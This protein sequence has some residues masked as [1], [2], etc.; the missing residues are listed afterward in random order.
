MKST[1]GIIMKEQF[2]INPIGS[3][4]SIIKKEKTR[5]SKAWLVW[6]FAGTAITSL[7]MVILF[8]HTNVFRDAI[9]AGLEL[10]NGTQA[11]D[12][13]EKPP[14]NPVLRV[15]IFNYTNVEEYA[16]G[17]ASKLQVE[18]LGPYIYRETISRVNVR[19]NENG[20][21]SYQEK[22]THK[23]EG[24]RS[25]DEMIRVPNVPLI[26]AVKK[27]RE[28]SRLLHIPATFG[29]TMMGAKPFKELTVKEY[30]WGYNDN[31][32]DTAM[33]I[34]S[35]TETLPYDKFGML[36]ARSGLSKD[37]LTVHT[38]SGDINN[39]GLY[40]NMNGMETRNVWGDEECDRVRGT[41]GSIFPPNLVRDRNAT[42]EIYTKDMCRTF[43]LRYH[44]DG[45]VFDI[46]SLRYKPT[47][48]IFTASNTTNSCFCQ[49]TS[50]G[51]IKEIQTCPPAGVFNISACSYNL[52]LLISFPHFYGGEKSLLNHVEGMSPCQE[53]HETYADLHPRLGVL[54]GGW[55]RLQI[56]V[57]VSVL[58]TVDMLGPL[59]DGAILPLVW[60]E[61]GVDKIPETILSMLRQG[62]FTAGTIESTLQWGSLLSMI[63]SLCAIAFM[64]KKHK[65]LDRPKW[66]SNLSLK[67]SC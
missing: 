14:V 63:S 50:N 24:G 20:T 66:Q 55:S 8:W 53:L 35:L 29:L 2:K 23:W 19:L 17:R 49:K 1:G 32:L 7:A 62:Y 59:K 31:L 27:A 11:F 40:Q 46:P 39:L 57:Q 12:W 34:M 61:M 15:R 36:L 52:P 10:K 3:E 18:E 48:D 64:M 56:N 41:D 45:S 58:D 65:E 21:V 9:L 6:F 16:A 30:L 47:K 54:I 33:N 22:T 28:V 37:R 43:P 38:G 5:T 42:L 4:V 26:M 67:T 25:V 13:W 51:N 44:G 60:F